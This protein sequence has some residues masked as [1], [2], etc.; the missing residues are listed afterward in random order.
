M[1]VFRSHMLICGG[2]GCHA[3]GSIDVRK[4]LVAEIAKRGLAE[5][6]KVVETGCNGFCAQG[7]IIVVYP[8]GIIYMMV[9]TDDIPELVEEHLIKGHVIQ[10]WAIGRLDPR[11]IQ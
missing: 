6:I 3:S 8:E 2:T 10:E 1:K 5:E 11:R 9:K 7:P 4:A